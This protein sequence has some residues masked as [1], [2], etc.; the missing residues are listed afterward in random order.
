MT[1]APRAVKIGAKRDHTTTVEIVGGIMKPIRVFAGSLVGVAALVT[2]TACANGGPPT[3]LTG[4]STGAAQVQNSGQSNA[5]AA[6]QTTGGAN[7]GNTI[8]VPGLPA[9]GLPTNLPGGVSGSL[10]AGFPLPPGATTSSVVTADGD[11]EATVQV[12]DASTAYQYWLTALPQAGYQIVGQPA[13]TNVNGASIAGINLSGHGYS[14]ASGIQITNGTAVI[15]LSGGGGT[16]AGTGSGGASGGGGTINITQNGT[17]TCNGGETVTIASHG[18]LTVT[19][20]GHCG[21]VEV[22]AGDNTVTVTDADKIGIG[23]ADNTVTYGG[24]PAVSNL[25]ANNTLRHS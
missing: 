14:A 22:D 13:I 23:G 4:N 6:G 10:P 25:G 9:G 3:G 5:A 17:Y 16:S 15:G 24:N 19:I 20:N 2:L 1:P 21:D 7:G 8:N 18:D 11:V 12:S